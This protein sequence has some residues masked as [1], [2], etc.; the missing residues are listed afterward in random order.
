MQAHPRINIFTIVGSI[1]ILGGVL[2][3]AYPFL[4]LIIFKFSGPQDSYSATQDTYANAEFLGNDE[5]L[6]NAQLPVS[7][8]KTATP[9]PSDRS[10]TPHVVI[11]KIGVDIPL[12]DGSTAATLEKG[13]WH[14]PGTANPDQIGNMIV[15][16]HRY[17]YRPP[18][19]KT[20]YL[21]DKLNIGDTFIVYWNGG[22]YRYRIDKKE[23]R[24]GNDL[25]IL[26]DTFDRRVTLIT[27]DPLFST[28]N[29][30]VVSGRLLKI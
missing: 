20:F 24:P 14:L 12:Y 8:D 26:T 21:L 10:K 2:L 7:E 3:A 19:S 23:V 18:S 11:E 1:L 22:G 28:K 15:T 27:C 9:A 16:A 29:R 30:L 4:P 13:A 25:S 6:T 5:Q 17:K